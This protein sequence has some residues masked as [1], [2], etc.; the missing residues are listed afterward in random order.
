MFYS[1]E[2]LHIPLHLPLLNLAHKFISWTG[3]AGGTTG[4]VWAGDVL[5]PFLCC[6]AESTPVG[7]EEG[8]DTGMKLLPLVPDGGPDAGKKPSTDPMAPKFEK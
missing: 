6:R 5:L 8:K 3:G 2:V 4:G 1:V 7:G